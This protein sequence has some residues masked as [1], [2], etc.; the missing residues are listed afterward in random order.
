MANQY[1]RP[2]NLKPYES[3][4]RLSILKK[5]KEVLIIDDQSTGRTILEKIVQQI[6]ENI[7]VTALSNSTEALEWL[8]QHEADL[9]VT[10]YRMPEIDGIEF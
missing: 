8:S 4:R 1:G 10:D 6:G 2:G 7:H 9:I 5:T 3:A